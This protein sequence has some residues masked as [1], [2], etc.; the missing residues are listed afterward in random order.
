MAF[1][2]VNNSE[3]YLQGK[4]YSGNGSTNA[5][6]F[7]GD[8]NTR[9][10]W[11]WIKCRSDGNGHQLFDVLRTTNS[12][13]SDVADAE[14]NRSGDGFTS[15]D[16]DGF[17]LNGSGSGGNVNVSGRT[18]IGWGWNA[19]GSG[20][21]NTDGSINTT[22]TSVS[23]TSGVSISTY[24][25][26]G[27]NATVGHGLGVTPGWIIV[28]CRNES[29]TWFVFHQ[30]LGGNVMRLNETN[31]SESP[32][33]TITSPNSTIFNIGTAQAVN[34]SSNTYV[35]YCF[36]EK[37]GFSKFGSYVGNGNADG[38]FVYCGFRPAWLMI[39]RTDASGDAWV[40]FDNKRPGHNLTDN[41][42]EA[43]A[44]GAEAVD[45]PNQRLDMLSNGFKIRGTGSATNTS[46]STYIFMA[47]AE[48]P[49]V[50]SNGVPNNAR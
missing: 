20:S 31:A 36:S 49:F 1:T 28:K 18:Y 10:D 39:K 45:N 27:S 14:A 40:L 25:G 6:T 48:S 13:S 8:E 17:T 29:Q 24:T 33:G 4:L 3:L 50:N 16:S 47:F 30:F 34:K 22:A 38:T 7:D 26:T 19:G 37:Q 35:A 44:S 43:D 2:E 32:S 21:A 9:P 42:L 41:F 11:L 23:T 46:G 15:L 5:I 12:L